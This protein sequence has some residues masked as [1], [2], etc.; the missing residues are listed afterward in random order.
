[1]AV[2]NS[3]EMKD[4]GQSHAATITTAH[5]SLVF[6]KV[7]NCASGKDHYISECL[8]GDKV[9]ESTKLLGTGSQCKHATLQFRHTG[10]FPNSCTP[11]NDPA[12]NLD[13]EQFSSYDNKASIDVSTQ[14]HSQG[15]DSNGLALRRTLSSESERL[16]MQVDPDSVLSGIPAFSLISRDFIVENLVHSSQNLNDE[17]PYPRKSQVMSAPSDAL[18]LLFEKVGTVC[19]LGDLNL[20]PLSSCTVHHSACNNVKQLQL[21]STA[22]KMDFI[23]ECSDLIPSSNDKVSLIDSDFK[24]ALKAAN[25][26]GSVNCEI[27]AEQSSI[28]LLVSEAVDGKRPC[29][30]GTFQKLP[31]AFVPELSAC[32]L[33]THKEEEQNYAEHSKQI[34]EEMLGMCLACSHDDAPDHTLQV[35]SNVRTRKDLDLLS[36]TP[37]DISLP[38]GV[39][40]P[41]I[42]ELLTF[43]GFL[44]K[45]VKSI[46]PK[47]IEEVLAALQIVLPESVQELLDP[48][49]DAIEEAAVELA[50][51]DAALTDKI[52]VHDQHI[53]KFEPN[54]GLSG[55][56]KLPKVTTP[57][58]AYALHHSGTQRSD[59]SAMV[60][61]KE[62]RISIQQTGLLAAE[63][64]ELGL[65]QDAM[66]N[67]QSQ[68][69]N[70][71][72]GNINPGIM[73]GGSSK[74]ETKCRCHLLTIF[75]CGI[76]LASTA[77]LGLMTGMAFS[78]NCGCW[79]L[80][81]A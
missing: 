70:A 21:S 55:S 50:E 39:L 16:P 47:D 8:A 44:L 18:G 1:V 33:E 66:I 5:A 79:C 74:V 12:K 7:E 13:I 29:L 49:F 30:H 58:A 26:T 3:L 42:Q 48:V 34:L 17:I 40:T 27:E 76:L 6:L 43:W 54:P 14:I 75:G 62:S 78:T 25:I 80:T 36:D 38:P 19:S 60:C 71:V 52:L 2:Q 9:E 64:H 46:G 59:S 32:A 81:D 72:L 28:S 65:P 73:D 37:Q 23:A 11:D 22:P 69:G 56:A 67:T 63:N 24:P 61:D 77:A 57:N 41:D 51:T 4:I 15:T 10:P 35:V 68:A 53:N 31:E 45:A 20:P